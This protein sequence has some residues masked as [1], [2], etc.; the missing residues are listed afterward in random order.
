MAKRG[1]AKVTSQ[2]D[3][4][5]NNKLGVDFI[6]E[7]TGTKSYMRCFLDN[8]RFFVLS[9]DLRNYEGGGIISSDAHK[10]FDSFTFWD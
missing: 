5:L 1:G 2:S 7:G 6:L 4:H 8:R 3:G 9:A 10:F